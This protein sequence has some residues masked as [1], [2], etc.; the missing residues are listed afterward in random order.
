MAIVG[1]NVET[2]EGIPGDRAE[3]PTKAQAE[4]GTTIE[5]EAL[6]IKIGMTI[7]TIEGT[8]DPTG[9][10][11]EVV[12]Q[13]GTTGANHH[14]TNQVTHYPGDS[15]TC[16]IQDLLHHLVRE[17]VMEIIVIKKAKIQKTS[18]MGSIGPTLKFRIHKSSPISRIPK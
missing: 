5:I 7:I 12:V 2:L 3:D 16:H 14:P 6:G 8:E 17:A 11:V 9:A 1:G 18:R 13:E 15:H 4:G 10:E